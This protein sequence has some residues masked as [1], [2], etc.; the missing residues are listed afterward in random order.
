MYLVLF[1]EEIFLTD[2]KFPTLKRQKA[3]SRYLA[4]HPRVPEGFLFQVR[5][6]LISTPLNGS[7]LHIFLC[8]SS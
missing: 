4:N 6:I 5:T 8:N 3:I 7:W 2:D 1:L